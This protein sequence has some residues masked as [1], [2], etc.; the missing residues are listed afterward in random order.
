MGGR[1]RVG[2]PTAADPS[3]QPAVAAT[4]PAFA[5]KPT[6]TRSG[7]TVRIEFAVDHK[8]D[9]AVTVED[10][11]WEELATL[12]A[13]S[14]CGRS[15]IE[16]RI[17]VLGTRVQKSRLNLPAGPSTVVLQFSRMSRPMSPSCATQG[18]RSIATSVGWLNHGSP[19]FWRSH[20]WRLATGGL[21]VRQG[22]ADEGWQN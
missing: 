3:E 10:A 22:A 12:Y 16:M 17:E 5:S 6:A 15:C 8:T 19:G 9:V 13:C 2:P 18:G 21:G 11:R 4:P 14:C 1:L 7:D 20:L